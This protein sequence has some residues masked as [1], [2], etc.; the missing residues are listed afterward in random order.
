MH[1]AT[2]ICSVGTWNLTNIS[3]SEVNV[4]WAAHQ[5]HH[6][7]EDYNL[8]TALRQ[9]AFQTFGAWVLFFHYI[10]YTSITIILAFL[11]SHGFLHPSQPS[12][13]SQRA[14][15]SLPVL[16]PHWDCEEYWTTG[17]C[18]QHSQSPQSSSWY[19]IQN[20]HLHSLPHLLQELTNIAWTRTMLGFWSSGSGK[21]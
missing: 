4:L 20:H 13:C 21:N 5:V 10:T 1:A 18:P 9:S 8:T 6:S 17:V 3:I 16:D 2:N 11:S 19:Q 14:E 7:S 15:P 12:N